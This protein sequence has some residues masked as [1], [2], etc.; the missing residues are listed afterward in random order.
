MPGRWHVCLGLYKVFSEGCSYRV[1]IEIATEPSRLSES[2]PFPLKMAAAETRF[3]G[4]NGFLCQ[5]ARHCNCGEITRPSGDLPTSMP[6][7][8]FAP[9]LRGELHCHTL[10]SDGDS[11]ATDVVNLARARGLDFLAISDHNSISAQRELANLR[12]P[13]LALIRGVEVTTFKGHF[14]V[15]GIGDWVD[16]RVQDAEDMAAALEF[17]NAR[18]AV[19][20]CNHPRP[21]GPPWDFETVTNYQCIEVWNGP[22]TLLNQIAVD[23]WVRQLNTDRRIPAIGGSDW[24]RHKEL[25]EQPPHAPGIPTTWVYV[26]ETPS[27]SSIL[28]AIRRGHVSLSDEPNGPLLDLRAGEEFIAMGGDSIPRPDGRLPVRVHCQRGAGYELQLL[29]QHAVLHKQKISDDDATML[30]ELPISNSAYVRAEL[31]AADESMKALTNPIYYS[32]I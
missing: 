10:H 30:V 21:F 20:A 24:H 28:Q 4:E 15:W 14:G 26:E 6:R 25:V 27:A 5:T 31:R 17:A 19:T 2:R 1:K 29:D 13:G 12:D 7:A 18:G 9:W 16:F 32:P 23:F 3:L 11:S 8:P 22:W